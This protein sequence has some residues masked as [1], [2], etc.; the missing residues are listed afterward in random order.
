MRA[1]TS[2]GSGS[3]VLTEVADPVRATPSDV[4]IQVSAS[5]VGRGDLNSARFATPDRPRVL[6]L[7]AVGTV[8]ETAED[9][10]GPAVGTRVM[11]YG[12]NRAGGWAEKAVLDSWLLTAIPDALNDE[13]AAALPNSGLAALAGL[14]AGGFLLGS[15]V[16][17]TGASGGVGV[18]ATQLAHQAGAQVT[19]AISG[20]G[21][22]AGLAGFDWLTVT[23]LD[24]VEGS[25]DLVVDLV[26]GPAL[27]KALT[28][29]ATD[30]VISSLAQAAPET[31]N[32]PSFWFAT[33]PGARLIG[34]VNTTGQHEGGHGVRRLELLANLASQGLLDPQIAT[35]ASWEETPDLLTALA[36]RKLSGR[37]AIRIS[38]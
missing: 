10:T 28:V 5:V 35:V 6:G 11:G 24:E 26:G 18:L 14:T 19:G 21:R 20:P 17:V 22:G 37:A 27:S 36:D 33:H 15:R 23:P 32:V 3:V 38:T 29:V 9:G 34:V 7:D 1:L 2:T 25:F 16:L 8:I 12:S 31:A 13:V 4:L 30:G